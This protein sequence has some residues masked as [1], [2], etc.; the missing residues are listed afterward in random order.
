MIRYDPVTTGESDRQRLQT[1]RTVAAS[2]LSLISPGSRPLKTI[3]LQEVV[4]AINDGRW[5]HCWLV[6]VVETDG[7]S[8]SRQYNLFLPTLAASRPLLAHETQRDAPLSA[9][10]VHILANTRLHVC[11]RTRTSCREQTDLSRSLY[12]MKCGFNGHVFSN[13]WYNYATYKNNCVTK[14]SK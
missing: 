8:Q 6:V 12:S 11:A 14:I 9:V 3:P 1:R 2:L 5:A 7:V 13:F 10:G 4:H